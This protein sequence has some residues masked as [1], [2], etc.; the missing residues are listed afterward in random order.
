MR[1]A[2][3]ENEPLTFISIGLQAALI[4]NRLRLQAQLSDAEQSLGDVVGN[5]ND[6]DDRA[7]GK[8]EDDAQ[9]K[10]VIRDKRIG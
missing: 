8:T 2:D 1:N 9:A 5:D 10:V 6:G 7:N 3:N 4:L